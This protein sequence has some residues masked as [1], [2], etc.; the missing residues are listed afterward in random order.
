MDETTASLDRI[1]NDKGYIEG[2]VQ[3]V[4]K[5]INRMKNIFEQNYFIDICKKIIETKQKNCEV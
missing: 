1:Q 3:W 5:D 2:N 4:H